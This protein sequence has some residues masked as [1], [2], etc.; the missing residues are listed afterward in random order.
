MNEN[1]ELSVSAPA[2]LHIRKRQR[3]GINGCALL[4][5]PLTGQALV[6]RVDADTVEVLAV[7]AGPPKEGPLDWVEFPESDL[8]VVAECI[9]QQLADQAQGHRLH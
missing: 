7:V 5:D 4:G 1:I 6:L 9:S 3:E 2:A 8:G